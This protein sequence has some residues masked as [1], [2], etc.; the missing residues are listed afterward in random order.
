MSKEEKYY[1]DRLVGKLIR[2]DCVDK[3]GKFTYFD[4][5]QVITDFL[6]ENEGEENFENYVIVTEQL[7]SNDKVSC[8]M[9]LEP[10]YMDSAEELIAGKWANAQV[11]HGAYKGRKHI[12][13]F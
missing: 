10:P 2:V 9:I 12:V 13:F 5:Y 8:E 11:L 4:G 7:V 1:H 3:N 6:I